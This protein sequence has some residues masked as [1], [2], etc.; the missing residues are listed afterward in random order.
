MD[1]NTVL[2]ILMF[3]T[4]I[5]LLFSGYPIAFVLSGVAVWYTIVGYF[6]DAYLGTMTGLSYNVIGMIVNRIYR[7]MNN[8]VMVAVPMLFLWD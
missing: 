6:C 1:T 7:V 8:W 2:V 5:A 3:L 4:F